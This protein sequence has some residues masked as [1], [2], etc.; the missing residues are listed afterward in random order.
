[1]VGLDKNASS[2]RALPPLGSKNQTYGSTVSFENISDSDS[3]FS[4][5]SLYST[6]S[7]PL[8]R[9]GLA[10]AGKMHM[11]DDDEVCGPVRRDRD[12][13]GAAP[14]ARARI[15]THSAR[16]RSVRPGALSTAAESTGAQ[17]AAARDLTT[18]RR[19]QL[20]AYSRTRAGQTTTPRALDMAAAYQPGHYHSYAEV[21]TRSETSTCIHS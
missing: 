15:R 10:R 13:T 21:P 2:D 7:S 17:G 6:L 11:I 19:R 18:A 9:F 1:M 20:C 14:P 3:L 8:L 16:T 5:I 12:A 4:G